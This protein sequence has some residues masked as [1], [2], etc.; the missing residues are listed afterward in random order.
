MTERTHR[1]WLWAV[2]A[3][4]VILR[5]GFGLT[6]SGLTASS[7]EP[8]WDG[9][10]RAFLTLGVMHPDIG[11]YRPPLYPLMLAGIY[12]VT[13]HSPFVVRMWQ[14]LLGVATCGLL[15]GIGRRIGGGTAGMIAAG[16]GAVYPVFVFFT[17]VLMA[18]TLLIF[19]TTAVLFV[20]LRFEAMSSYGNAVTLG[21]LAGL[22]ALCKPVVFAWVPLLLW[23]WWRGC[24]LAYRR[25]I[26]RAAVVAG[27]MGLTLLPWTARNAV[28]SGYFV[29]VSSNLGMN[30]MIG[31]EPEATGVYRNEA[32]YLGLF[33]RITEP[34]AHPVARDRMAARQALRWIAGSPGRFAGLA[35]G[36]LVLLW[37]P[38][39][40]GESAVRNLMALLSC[41]PV[42][43]LG[44]WGIFRLRGRPE[45]WGVG[46][47][48]MALSVVH[49][50][51][52]AHTRFRM[53]A[54]AALMGPAA[55]ML[56]QWWQKRRR[57]KDT[58]AASV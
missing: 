1:R 38:L 36:K 47:L 29:P 50:V 15:Y 31:N 17:G 57:G 39:V 24:A 52:F 26:A 32:D 10:A 22:A 34:S 27:A 2:L 40:A 46:S 56:A 45:A 55:W 58:G 8:E 4:A 16:M 28:I 33:G 18:E 14:A 42:L 48:L 6:R 5:A 25:R 23:G 43:A 12:G 19:L 11:I 51:F 3:L 44:V 13:G 53:P 41:G 7:D 21:I 9:A 35:V 54:D 49:A 20:W 30:L 37:H